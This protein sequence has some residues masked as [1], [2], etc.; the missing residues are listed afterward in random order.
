M[1]KFRFAIADWCV[2]VSGPDVCRMAAEAGLDG[3]ELNLGE[4]EH[5]L[6]LTDPHVRR[7][8]LDAQQRYG[9]DFC[10]IAVNALD[11]SFVMPPENP[12]RAAERSFIMKAAVD[13]AAALKIPIIQ[14]P[15]F[16]QNAIK[17]PEELE[18]A[19]GY[20]REACDEA[21]KHGIIVSSENPMSV[22][23]NLA[24]CDLVDRPNFRLYFDNE[25]PVYFNGANS[26]EMLRAL[27]SR[28]CQIHV[29]DG[30]D[31]QMSSCHLGQGH[32]YFHECVQV[33]H[34][35][36]YTG[37]I[38]SENNY[39]MPPFNTFENDR[40]ELLVEDVRIMKQAFLQKS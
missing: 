32:A 21:E 18:I 26:A 37:W 33:I 3:V 16:W 38:V 9:V 1:C 7:Y 11:K 25:N 23:D 15:S 31:A 36:G 27:G 34:E 6:P 29:K 24:L 35:I 4:F 8:Y 28:V 40:F 5:N 2:P 30:T 39:D 12:Q 22:E 20:F 17:T 19:A 10:S 14:V 13:T